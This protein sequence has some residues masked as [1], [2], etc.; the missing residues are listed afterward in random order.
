MNKKEIHIYFKDSWSLLLSLTISL[1]CIIILI[2]DKING[3]SLNISMLI[4]FWSNII[5]AE[6]K[7]NRIIFTKAL[8]PIDNSTTEKE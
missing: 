3:N 5:L 4:M 1:I 8:R 6:V 7:L 2:I